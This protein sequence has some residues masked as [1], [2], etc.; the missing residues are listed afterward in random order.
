M[1]QPS[2]W[3]TREN[4]KGEYVIQTQTGNAEMGVTSL[5]VFSCLDRLDLGALA[6]ELTVSGCT[7]QNSIIE[8]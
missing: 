7:T 5:S 3:D 4:I 2:E 8:Y 1:V 6:L